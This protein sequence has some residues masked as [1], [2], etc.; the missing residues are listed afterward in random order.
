MRLLRQ[1]QAFF[2]FF[3]KKILC[4]Q[5]CESNQNQPTKQKQAQTK[6][7]RQQFFARTK[8]SK[9][10][11]VICF[12]FWYFFAC[13]IFL[14]KK[15]KQ[16]WNCLDGLILL[17]YW[18]VPLSTCLWR[19]YLYALMLARYIIILSLLTCTHPFPPV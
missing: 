4:I 6:E 1:F 12:G 14:L 8:T 5:K 7:L 15:N 11:K 9:R 19:I 13:K 16:V 3:Y 10:V 17:Y 2:F 18:W